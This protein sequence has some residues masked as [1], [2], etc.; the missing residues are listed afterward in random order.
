MCHHFFSQASLLQEYH[1]KVSSWD[2]T[3]TLAWWHHDIAALKNALTRNQNYKFPHHCAKSFLQVATLLQQ[4][5]NKGRSNYDPG[6]GIHC[7]L[8]FGLLRR[9]S[10]PPILEE[11]MGDE[12]FWI[13]VGVDGTFITPQ[14]EFSVVS[15]AMMNKNSPKAKKQKQNLNSISC[16]IWPQLYD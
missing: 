5:S 9:G 13:T 3:T 16:T 2:N 8:G 6:M 11:S 4:G 7:F 14:C 10:T 12:G 15:S 1:G